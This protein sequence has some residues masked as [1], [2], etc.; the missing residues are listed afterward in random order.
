MLKFLNE[1]H[2]AFT[3]IELLVVIAIIGLLS[4]IVL[5]S[6][7]G[8]RE[9]AQ[10]AKGLDFSNSI[11]NAL[12]VDAVGVWSFETLE[13]G[14]IVLD[15][16]GYGNN[17]TVTGATLVAGMEQLGNA[18]SFD[19]ND[20]VSMGDRAMLEPG[21]ITVEAW[22]SP[23]VAIPADWSTIVAKGYQTTYTEYWLHYRAGYFRLEFGNGT[24]NRTAVCPAVTISP[25]GWYHVVGTYTAGGVG[26][27]YVNGTRGSA[28]SVL[29]GSLV[30]DAHPFKIGES[31]YT[32]NYYFTGLIDE[33]RIYEIALTSAQLQ[34]QYYAGLDRLLAKG[35]MDRGEYEQRLASN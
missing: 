32:T 2:K 10:I 21:S 15:S 34:S 3:L 6:M 13:T 17:G 19:G 27:C 31:S 30:G 25:G 9:K 29:S 1:K 16:S 24:T 7:K 20:G 14:N 4:S 35:L 33:V 12:G 22:V 5:V 11:Q 28:T 26:Y 23:S 8:V 18:L